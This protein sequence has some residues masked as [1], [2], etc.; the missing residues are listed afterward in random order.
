MT[1]GR[2][3]SVRAAFFA[4]A[5]CNRCRMKEAAPQIRLIKHVQALSSPWLA[6]IAPH[7][8][9]CGAR[10]CL[11]LGRCGRVTRADSAASHDLVAATVRGGNHASTSRVAPHRPRRSRRADYRT[12]NAL[13]RFPVCLGGSRQA[14]TSRSA[15][16]I[17]SSERGG[18]PEPL[19]GRGQQVPQEALL[20]PF[21]AALQV[22]ISPRC[23]R[24]E[25]PTVSVKWAQQCHRGW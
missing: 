9:I 23:D 6:G 3:K 19:E 11:G 7:G 21:I 8:A 5:K 2:R 14:G 1:M 24:Q 25:T 12:V 17:G 13:P 16:L 4:R 18:S 22:G 10:P 15:R 20:R